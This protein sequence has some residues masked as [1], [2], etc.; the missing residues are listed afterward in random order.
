LNNE[1]NR[2]RQ[3]SELIRAGHPLNLEFGNFSDETE[4]DLKRLL[5]I[6]REAGG[7]IAVALDRMSSVIVVREQT[8]NELALAVAGPKAS[9]RLVMALPVLVFLGAGISGIPIFRT[10]STIPI[11]WVSLGVGALFFWFGNRWI[12]KLL[13]RAEPRTS[14]PGLELDGLSIAVQAGMPLQSAIDLLEFQGS[15]SLSSLEAN[16][17][18]ALAQLLTERASQLRQQQF[19]EDRLLIQKTGVSVLWPLGLTLLPAFVLIAIVPVAAALIQ[20][21]I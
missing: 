17:G 18:I 19:N 11:V 6:S 8:R 15:E 2:L 4:R 14:D 5:A 7:P 20:D 10:L 21:Q 12:S 9:S 1:A 13:A 3:Y 16:S